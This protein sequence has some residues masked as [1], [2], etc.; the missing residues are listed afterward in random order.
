M[1]PWNLL[2]AKQAQLPQH[3]FIDGVHH[4]D[5]LRGPHLDSLQQLHI[6]PV[7]QASG[8]NTVL[9][10]DLHKGRVEGQNNSPLPA[11]HPSFDVAHDN[12]D[13]QATE[14]QYWVMSRFFFHQIPQVWLWLVCPVSEPGFSSTAYSSTCFFPS[15]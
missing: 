2:Q 3:F 8:L 13:I 1:S 9:Q 10:M 6:L 4:F 7:L 12:A 5:H 11:D 15:R 14:A